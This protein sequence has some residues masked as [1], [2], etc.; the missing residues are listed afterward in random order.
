MTVLYIDMISGISGDMFAGALIDL[1]LD[2]EE[3]KKILSCLPIKNEFEISVD[4]KEDTGLQGTDFKVLLSEQ[5]SSHSRTMK[6][7]KELLDISSLP[8]KTKELSIE[9]FT[10]LAKAEGAVHHQQWTDVHFH[11]VGAVDSIVD[12]V[13]AAFGIEYFN[14]K[15]CYSSP[16]R[17]GTGH[18]KTQHGKLPVP[19]P[20]VLE[21]AQTSPSVFTGISME[22]TTPTGAAIIRTIVPEPGKIPPELILKGTGHGWGKNS[23]ESMPNMLRIMKGEESKLQ[24]DLVELKTDIDDSTPETIGYL[25]ERLLEE[26]ALD[27]AAASV[28]MK[29]GRPGNRISVITDRAHANTL[30]RVLFRETTTLGIREIPITR[31]ILERETVTVSLDEGDITCKIGYLDDEQVTVA[32]EYEDCRKAAQDSGSP[33]KE[34]Y[35]KALRKAETILDK[36]QKEE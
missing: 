15:N 25:F 23:I 29:K 14:P 18:V 12:I 27:A 11:E 20:A 19:V 8:Q 16:F 1:G 2:P 28:I 13:T 17:F 21:L 34:I 31:T 32:P 35:S 5:S 9:I 3:L 7:I 22:L 30:K 6:D 36:R 26:G 33:L 4:S 24:A 10:V